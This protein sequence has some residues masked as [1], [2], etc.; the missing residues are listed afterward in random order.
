MLQD[1]EVAP[2]VGFNLIR[3]EIYKVYRKDIF[4]GLANQ[5]TTVYTIRPRPNH[6]IKVLS[7]VCRELRGHVLIYYPENGGPG[8]VTRWDNMTELSQGIISG[9]YLGPSEKAEKPDAQS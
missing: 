8:V 2:S 6:E 5:F 4:E 1:V 3:G 7:T 9:K